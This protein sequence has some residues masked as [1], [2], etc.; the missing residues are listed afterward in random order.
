MGKWET[1]S[2][3]LKFYENPFWGPG[4]NENFFAGKFYRNNLE[5]NST[6]RTHNSIM[7][8]VATQ[9]GGVCEREKVAEVGGDCDEEDDE[10]E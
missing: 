10:E 1:F 9:G 8:M 6:H 7:I 5:L 2:G 3:T 4:R